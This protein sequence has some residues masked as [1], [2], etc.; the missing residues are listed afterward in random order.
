MSVPKK[1]KTSGSKKRRASHFALK[2][3]NLVSAGSEMVPHAFK[4]AI[5]LKKNLKVNKVSK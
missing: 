4:K 1:R 3:Q 5:S 2:A